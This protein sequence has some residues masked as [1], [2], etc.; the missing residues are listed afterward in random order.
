MTGGV[1]NWE[2]Y[3]GLEL[4]TKRIR[5]LDFHLAHFASPVRFIGFHRQF[6]NRRPSVLQEEGSFLPDNLSELS[7]LNHEKKNK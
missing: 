5:I 3:L 7:V 4:G 6:S 2:T 1:N